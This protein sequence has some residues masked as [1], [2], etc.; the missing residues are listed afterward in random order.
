MA[1]RIRRY[2]TSLSSLILWVFWLKLTAASDGS[3]GHYEGGSLTWIAD[4]N[5]PRNVNITFQLNFRHSYFN[6]YL[7]EQCSETAIREKEVLSTEGSFRVDGERVTWANYVCT[8]F[9]EEINWSTGS[10]TFTHRLTP[11]Q[12]GIDVNFEECCWLTE[13]ANNGQQVSEGRGWNLASRVD[14]SP[15]PDN[16]KVNSPPVSLSLPVYRMKKGCPGVLYIPASDLDD[17]VIRCRWTDRDRRECNLHD[18]DVCGPLFVD[19]KR[20]KLGAELEEDTCKLTFRAKNPVGIYA[21]SVMLEDFAPTD[22]TSPLSKIPLQFLFEILPNKGPCRQPR[23]LGGHGECVT[24]PAGQEMQHTILAQSSSPEFEITS[25]DTIKSRGIS[26]SPV[27]KVDGTDADYFITLTWTPAIG[28]LGRHM[29]CYRA[30]EE[31]DFSSDAACVYINVVDPEH[32]VPFFVMTSESVPAPGSNV[33]EREIV[34]KFNKQIL[35]PKESGFVTIVDAEGEVMY[36]EDTKRSE[37][38]GND[39]SFSL[40]F[41]LV[42]GATYRIEVDS[43]AV[44]T[45]RRCEARL[46]RTEWSFTWMGRKL[47]AM[48]EAPLRTA[49]PRA[50]GSSP[51]DCHGNFMQVFVSKRLSGVIDPRTMYLNDQRC[52]GMDYNATHYVIGTSYNGCETAVTKEE[53]GLEIG[54]VTFENTAHIPPQPYTSGSEITRDHNIEIHLGCRVHESSVNYLSFDPNVTTLVF[55]DE[56]YER[57]NFSLEMFDDGSFTTPLK[58]NTFPMKVQLHDMMHFEARVKCHPGKDCSLVLDRCWATPSTNPFDFTRFPFLEDGCPRDDT[59]QLLVSPSSSR[60]RFSLSSFAFLGEH[61]ING[62][63]YVHCEMRVCYAMEFDAACET[64]CTDPSLEEIFGGVSERG[65]G[66]EVNHLL[67]HQAKHGSSSPGKTSHSRAHVTTR[68]VRNARASES[69]A[70]YHEYSPLGFNADVVEIS[71][72]GGIMALL[73]VLIGIHCARWRS[74]SKKTNVDV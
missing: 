9:D 31:G 28:Q 61:H 59:V 40:P 49:R 6:G 47:P 44:R 67:Q 74:D 56:G 3:Q 35:R 32:F 15:R 14:I 53:N 27:K 41:D 46:S 57:Y 66:D 11:E 25:I 65:S 4:Q 55:Y 7:H 62:P 26:V 17:D 23:V 70:G 64:I 36:T 20:K 13:I 37:V 21:V 69:G 39:L 54:L 48:I 2:A 52:K 22:L 18:G 43:D 19:S 58:S 50:P 10:F 38:D 45:R 16:N 60:K 63:V 12:T 1:G 24:V 73:M 51:V 42:Y 30:E 29:V 33:T 34:I 8:D 68:H 5:N 72:L 71:M